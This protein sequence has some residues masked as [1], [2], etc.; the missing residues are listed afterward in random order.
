M[1]MPPI[2]SSRGAIVALAALHAIA[3]PAAGQQIHHEWVAAR[4]EYTHLDDTAEPWQYGSVEAGVRRARLTSIGRLNLASR[5]GDSGQ[6]IEV[7][8]YPARAGLG[9]AYLSGAWSEGG[10]FPDLRLAA[11]LF[12]TLP[13]AYEASAGVV[14]MDFG[15]DDVSILVASLGRY[16]GNYWVAVRPSYTTVGSELAVTL[17]ARRYLRTPGEFVTARLFAGSTP[18][19][20]ATRGTRLETLGVQADG[21]LELTRRW[22]ILPLVAVAREEVSGGDEEGTRLRLTAGIGAMYRF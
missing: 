18:E 21:Q 5:F 22:L 7:D 20:I 14:Y 1:R 10:P 12:A 13:R 8:L 9:Y 17:T 6:Q 19:E 11:E 16:M 3:A 2:P 4:Y 15:G